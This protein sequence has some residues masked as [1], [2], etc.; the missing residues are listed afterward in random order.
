MKILHV[1]NIANIPYTLSRAQRELGVQSDVVDFRENYLGYKSD[2]NLHLEK[3]N[4]PLNRLRYFFHAAKEY[5]IFHLHS[6]ALLPF[7][8]DAPLL[9][10]AQKKTVYHHWGSDVRG[11]GKPLFSAFG[12]LHLVGTP[13]LLEFV[14]DA[15]W[16]PYAINLENFR[17]IKTRRKKTINIVH[18]S[19][20]RKIKGTEKI[21]QVVKELEKEIPV[22]LTLIEGKKHETAVK[23]YEKADIIIDQLNLGFYGTL[24]AE[25]MAMKKPV[26]CYLRPDLKKFI[27][28]CPIV[29]ANA[30]TLKEQLYWLATDEKLRESLG[31]K[32]KKYAEKVHD[33]KKIAKRTLEIYSKI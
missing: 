25:C 5:D 1:N 4:Q 10:L 24:A 8:A 22:E 14:P 11:K 17:P 33:A 18:A 21:I 23:I 29:D 9:R 32:G 31:K 16:V 20:N 6:A 26:V 28:D 15:E 12:N 3:S 2:F 13:D 7:Y 27:P 19:T 30:E